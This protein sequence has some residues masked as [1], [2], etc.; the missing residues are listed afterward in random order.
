MGDA[1]SGRIGIEPSG[2]HSHC[3]HTKT[4][5]LTTEGWRFQGF[6]VTIA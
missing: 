5:R 6:T 3:V 1:D 2:D 4:H